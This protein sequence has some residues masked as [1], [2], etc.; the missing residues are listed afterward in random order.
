M[1]NALKLVIFNLDALQLALPLSVVERVIHVVKVTPCPMRRRLLLALLTYM[2]AL[3]LLLT[4]VNGF[5]C[6]KGNPACMTSLC[7]YKRQK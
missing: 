6:R 4:F 1:E 3:F 2:D 5:G 7:F